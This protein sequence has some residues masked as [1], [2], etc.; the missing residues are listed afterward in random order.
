[1]RL[2]HIAAII[3]LLLACCVFFLMHK[4]GFPDKITYGA[5]ILSILFVAVV[6]STAS[7]ILGGG[8]DE[9]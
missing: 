8:D 9:E 6:W 3:G 1:M 4:F 5:A 7:L 2:N